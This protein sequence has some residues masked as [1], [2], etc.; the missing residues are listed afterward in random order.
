VM[1]RERRRSAMGY[2]Q[3]RPGDC[4]RLFL[5][6]HN[7]PQDGRKERHRLLHC[8]KIEI[9]LS[10]IYHLQHHASSCDALDA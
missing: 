1:S 8:G 7:A 5:Q 9:N 4:T 6:H 10:Y 2:P 3:R